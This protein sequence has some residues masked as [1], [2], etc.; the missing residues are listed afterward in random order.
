MGSFKA[1]ES[2]IGGAQCAKKLISGRAGSTQMNDS[3]QPKKRFVPAWIP[4][5]PVASHSPELNREI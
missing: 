4:C 3:G 1:L 2:E 5:T